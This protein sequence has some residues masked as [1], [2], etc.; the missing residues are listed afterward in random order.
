MFKIKS[1]TELLQNKIKPLLFD[2]IP[3]FIEKIEGNISDYYIVT[4]A[5]KPQNKKMQN[6]QK[7]IYHIAEMLDIISYKEL[8]YTTKCT[9]LVYNFQDIYNEEQSQQLSEA[10]LDVAEEQQDFKTVYKT[11]EK[12]KDKEE[13]TIRKGSQLTE[14]QLSEAGL[15]V[16]TLLQEQKIIEIKVVK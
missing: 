9:N 4:N 13:N 1:E 15:D 16:D 8:Q 2:G 11:T 6:L 7:G 5:P 14:K 10:G 3:L 12:L